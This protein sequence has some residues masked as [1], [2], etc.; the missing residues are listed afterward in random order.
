MRRAARIDDNQKQIVGELRQ[1]PGCTVTSTA[2]VGN[3]FPDI[4]VGYQG[5][6]YLFEIKDP[7]KPPSAR[8]LTEHEHRFHEAWT[9]QISVIQATE[10]AMEIMGIKRR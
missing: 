6:N 1:L 4:V 2:G 3:G 5:I 9:G 10:E 7:A 8:K